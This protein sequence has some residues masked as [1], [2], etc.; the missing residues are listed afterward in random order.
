MRLNEFFLSQL[1]KKNK[2]V[3]QKRHT[4]TNPA[5]TVEDIVENIFQ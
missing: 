3:K 4:V 2:L 1:V 5:G